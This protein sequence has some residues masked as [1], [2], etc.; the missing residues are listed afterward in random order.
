MSLI[1]LAPI[2]RIVEFELF[3][4]EV[5]EVTFPVWMHILITAPYALSYWL[6]SVV[7]HGGLLWLKFLFRSLKF[8]GL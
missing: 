5:L 4:G 7:D 6:L 8:C 2:R 1:S 3:E